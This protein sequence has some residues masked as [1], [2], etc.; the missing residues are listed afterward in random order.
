MQTGVQP[1][2][3]SLLW[4]L[5]AL[6]FGVVAGL[7]GGTWYASR[8]AV[9]RA[10]QQLARDL[11]G[12]FKAR[13][14]ISPER[15]IGTLRQRPYVLETGLSHEDDAPYFHTRGAFPLR[16]P[17]SII[18]G[19]RRKSLLEEAQTRRDR[20]AFDLEDGDFHRQF[21]V[22]CNDAQVL[23][24]V[25]TSAVRRELGRYS[26]VEIYVRR[27]ELEWRRAGAQ[28]DMR[29]I[30][31]LNDLLAD[32]AETID[33]LPKRALT[34]SELLADEELIAKGV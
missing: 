33:A 22:V 1:T 25:L 7:A 32:M 4:F 24:E 23:P 34:L 26:D 28:G 11:D 15:V 3:A 29:A 19:V 10:W 5:I 6:T 31:R 17:A 21:F 9:V 13:N 2:N 30:R 12:E 8:R 14:S 27:G 16:N 18:L 20:P